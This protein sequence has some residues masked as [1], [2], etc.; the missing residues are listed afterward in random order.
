M[1]PLPPVACAG[2][3]KNSASPVRGPESNGMAES[4]MKTFKW[5]YVFIHERHD[6]ATV[7]A[8]LPGWFEDYNERHPHKEQRLKSFREFIRSSSTAE[9]PV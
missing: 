4:L 8:Q 6:A 7:L 5:D 3:A 9:G 2:D 1:F